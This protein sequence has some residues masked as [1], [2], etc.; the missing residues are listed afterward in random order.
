MKDLSTRFK[1]SLIAVTLLFSVILSACSFRMMYGYLDWILPWYL[2]DYV[3][4]TDQQ[5]K[6][7]DR[8]TLKFLGWHRSVELPRYAAFFNTI[9][10]AQSEPMGPQQVLLFFDEIQ[11]MWVTLLDESMP[12]LLLLAQDFSDKQVQQ[13]DRA[14]LADNAELQD[15]HGNRSDAEQRRYY[16]E[17]MLENLE[18]WI[19][20]I[21]EEQ[22]EIVY[23]WSL[24]RI[25]TTAGWLEHRNKWRERF[26][27]L[28]GER[29]SPEFNTQ[30]QQFLLEPQEFYIPSYRHAVEENRLGFAQLIADLSATLTS[31]QRVH[32]QQE[33]AGVIGDLNYLSNQEG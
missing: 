27:E 21:T 17:K 8:A 25:N 32:F 22:E 30:M 28:L 29:S 18:D 33:L 14:L 23:N 31:G 2:D 12:D 10:D 20:N 1:S 3:T 5:E 15:K 26:I 19:G 11:E 6:V 7:F 9:K 16:R 24:T 4:L 13:I